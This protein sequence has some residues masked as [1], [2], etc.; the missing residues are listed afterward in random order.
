MSTTHET[1]PARKPQAL[2]VML[3]QLVDNGRVDQALGL[4]ESLTEAEIREAP[5]VEI[6]IARAL[7]RVGRF[8]KAKARVTAALC[9]FRAKRNVR[10][11][12]R[13]NLVL[14]GI[15][16]EQG[17]LE[18]AEYHFGVTRVLALALDDRQVLSQVTNN[19]ACL[20]LQRNDFHAAEALLQSALRLAR[21]LADLRAQADLLHNLNIACRSLGQFEAAR[22]AG[23]QALALAEGMEDWSMVALALGGLAETSSWSGTADEKVLLDRA[24]ASARRA[25]DGVREAEIGRVRAT[26]AL[27]AGRYGD[28]HRL[29]DVACQLAETQGSSLVV[30]ECTGIKAV[31]YKREGNL[32]EAG[33][34]RERATTELRRLNAYLEIAWFD[35]EWV[36]AT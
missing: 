18:N 31:A 7:A 6:E 19:L 27:G 34:F 2:A 20:T 9:G 26:L 36:I 33:R 3:R 22:Q 24:E 23:E 21:E 13:A 25:G 10:G 12:M 17:H 5:E 14:G 16:F 32:A 30:A 1:V 8:D 29:A 15:S 28:A 4:S 11:Q 35:R